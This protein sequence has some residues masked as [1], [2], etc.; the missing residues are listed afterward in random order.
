MLDEKAG[1]V[2]VATRREH[3]LAEAFLSAHSVKDFAPDLP[4]TLFTDL[5]QSPFANAPLFRQSR[6]NR[7]HAH[8]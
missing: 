5:P 2:Y 7:Y 3:Y 6:T 4:I 1:I 8:I